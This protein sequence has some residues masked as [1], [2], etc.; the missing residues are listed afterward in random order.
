VE[1]VC[2]CER[3]V[4]VSSKLGSV[5]ELWECGVGWVCEGSL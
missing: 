5:K 3:S 4:G 1:G 2:E